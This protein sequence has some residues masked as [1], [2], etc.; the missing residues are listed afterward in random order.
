M[1]GGLRGGSSLIHSTS[2]SQAP[3]LSQVLFLALGIWQLTKQ[4]ENLL[5]WGWPSRGKCEFTLP[6]LLCASHSILTAALMGGHC[7][8]Y[9]G[10]TDK[11][12]RIVEADD[13]PQSGARTQAS[14]SM[15]EL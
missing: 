15:S 2:T 7:C 10:S 13:V 9:A 14:V 12:L 1:R 11:G 5:R 6:C 4:P 8:S 3:R